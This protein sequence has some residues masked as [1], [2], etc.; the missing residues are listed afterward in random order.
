V[1]SQVRLTQA[2]G[3][4][5][6]SVV[7][8]LRAR[9]MDTCLDAG[10][11]AALVRSVLESHGVV[12]PDVRTDG[13]VGGPLDQLEAIQ[14]HV[15]DG[16]FIYATVGYTAEG[17]RIFYL[18]GNQSS[19]PNSSGRRFCSRRATYSSSARVTTAVLVRSPLTSSA[20]CNSQSVSCRPTRT[21]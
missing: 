12:D 8:D 16:C 19:A 18:A 11:A 20:R 9:L 3:P 6:I 21:L 1:A 5:L 14:Q 4:E 10:E 2:P 17:H 7:D 15:D 13:P